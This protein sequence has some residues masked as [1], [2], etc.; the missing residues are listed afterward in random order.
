MENK[1]KTDRCD[2][3]KFVHLL[4]IELLK[5][6]YV[7]TE[8]ELYHLQVLRRRSQLIQDRIRAQSRIK[9]ELRFYGIDIPT[10]RGKWSKTYVRNLCSIR[11]GNKWM[12]ESFNRLLETYDLLYTQVDKQTRLIKEL[13]KHTVIRKSC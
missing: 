9:A 12:Q 7:P 13:A 10:S 8:E 2:S 3:R 6:V 4:V 5:S 1:V 11:F